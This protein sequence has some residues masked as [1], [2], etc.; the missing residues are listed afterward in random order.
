[1][2]GSHF[3]VSN[4]GA[5]GPRLQRA[6]TR[7]S[8]GEQI[9]KGLLAL[10]ALLSVL[11]TT[12]IVVTL[13]K[14][15]I[16]FFGDVPIG[17]FLFKTDWA[18]L[19]GGEQQA[20]GVVP[21][22]WSTLYLTAVGLVVAIPAG[23]GVGIYLAEYAS[24]RVR[25]ILKP[26]V[27]LLAGIPTIVFGY[28]ALT[29]FTPN[30]IQDWIGIGVDVFNGLS[31]GIILGILV[32]PTIASVSED[33]MSAVPQS[34]REGAFGLGAA[35][36][37]VVLRVVFPAALSGI[38]AALVLGASRAIGETVVILVAAGNN[39][40]LTFDLTVAH[41]NMAAF[42]ANTA[43]ADVSAGSIAYETI[44]AVG[45]TLFVM[46]LVLNLIAI[47]FVRKYRQVYE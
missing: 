23:L 25:K 21:L 44:F 29:F 35:K 37:Q 16:T 15:T 27:E 1:M 13:I 36:W 18:P 47:R 11:T 17:D 28:F 46:T 2:E 7:R 24:P 40:N 9:I 20:F 30:V 19:A 42:I 43:R 6:R 10:A 41:Q 12:G 22:I 3:A 32:L 33:A 8:T 34:L 38:V 31:A 26:V 4:P 14:E 5:Q 45:T 39:P